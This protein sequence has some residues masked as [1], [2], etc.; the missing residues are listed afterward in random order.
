MNHLLQGPPMPCS[1]QPC[2]TMSAL[3]WLLQG[4]PMPCPTPLGCSNEPRHC[5]H[6]LSFPCT[7]VAPLC[8]VSTTH[9]TWSCFLQLHHGMP[10][11]FLHVAHAM[12]LCPW[13]RGLPQCTRLSAH[14]PAPMREWLYDASCHYGHKLHPHVME[15]MCAC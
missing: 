15:P 10:K 5:A 8:H 7:R 11:A 1:C 2:T 3:I 9:L 4:H 12:A 14:M 13:L 6:G